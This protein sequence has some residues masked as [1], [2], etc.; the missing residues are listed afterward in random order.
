MN[1]SGGAEGRTDKSANEKQPLSLE[2]L[3]AT[4]LERVAQ[5]PAGGCP[6]RYCWW[7]CSSL[8]RWELAVGEGCTFLGSKKPKGYK[9]SNE[10]CCRSDPSSFFDQFEPREPFIEADQIDASKWLVF[11]DQ[12]TRK[13]ETRAKGAGDS[14]DG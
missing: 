11:R 5:I 2:V 10:P 9:Y 7:W 8:F 3:P 1:S 6:R 12:T 13:H 4:D 14:S